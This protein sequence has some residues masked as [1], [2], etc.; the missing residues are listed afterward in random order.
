MLSI[1]NTALL[2]I[3]MQVKLTRVMT[4]KESLIIN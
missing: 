1:E 3:D 4:D 2:V